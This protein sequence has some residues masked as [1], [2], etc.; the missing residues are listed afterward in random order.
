M[1]LVEDHDSTARVL[2]RQLARLQ[3]EVTAVAS[4]AEASDLLTESSFDLMVCDLT[5]P[6]GSAVEF[7]RRVSA[8]RSMAGRKVV[9]SIALRGYSAAEDDVRAVK[10]AGFVDQLVKP[11]DLNALATAI[12]RITG[13]R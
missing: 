3:C 8:Q 10:A 11:V 5:M 4:L 6:D 12:G 2:T 1:L 9:P 7:V 13:R